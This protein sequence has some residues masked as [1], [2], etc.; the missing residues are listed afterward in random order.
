MSFLKELTNQLTGLWGGWSRSQ[1]VIM[2]VSG[3]VC[4][5]S[6]IGVGVWATRPEYIALIDHLGPG[7]AAEVVSTLE[8]AG[9]DYKLN[10]SGSA[11]SVPRQSV[12]T[13]RLALKDVIDTE[14]TQDESLDGGIWSDP[15]LSHVRILRQQ[16]SRL[17]RS[18][19]QMRTVRNATV[20]ISQPEPT[21]F[22]RDRESTKAS[23]VL[24]LKP[25]THFTRADAQSIV[26]LVS[27]GVEGLDPMNV[28]VLD[29]EGR[30]LSSTN[31]F[32]ADVTGQLE[33]R[34]R[35]ES[36][37]AAKA[38]TMLSQLL[39]PGRAVVRVT[40]DVDFT[41]TERE[42]TT[43]DPDGKVKLSEEV[44]SEQTTG[45][46]AAA[47]GPAGT[48]SNVGANALAG[49]RSPTTTKIESN[50]T[51]YAN[52]EVRDK[53]R[54]A[55]GKIRRLTVAAIVSLP[56]ATA[57]AGDGTAAA[58]A[59]T[60]DKTQIESI[61]KQA[62]G[63]DLQRSDE[64][65]VLDAPLLGAPEQFAPPEGFAWTQ[66]EKLLRTLSLGLASIVALLLGVLLIRR[67]KPVIVEAEGA[68]DGSND[69][70]QRINSLSMEAR[71]NPEALATAL[72]VW[73][74]ETE[75]SDDGQAP[76]T[77]PGRGK[78]SARAA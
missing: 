28:T 70:A 51:E 45:M 76:Q 4:L 3:V 34:N 58:P 32:D 61:I 46:Q 2:V 20:H 67:M 63:F 15:G 38:E 25:G 9:I 18:I 29:T 17:A 8:S 59:P 69:V 65:E 49:S 33:Y 55:P 52:A 53:V 66:Y 12:S 36:D 14:S 11:V 42:E 60:Y 77:V 40:A 74:G 78:S 1:Q 64:I 16:E 50:K 37:L 68:G 41:E 5:A 48:A 72:S 39:G 43:Y 19:A 75:T 73:L 47:A 10:F 35:L 7:E 6:I 56:S 62:V 23:V 57:D 22:V 13:A 30:L 27:H 54:E 44:T 26:S 71:E 24:D 21:P 31:G